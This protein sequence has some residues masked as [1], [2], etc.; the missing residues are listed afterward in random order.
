MEEENKIT[1][2]K[3]EKE[4]RGHVSMKLKINIWYFLKWGILLSVNDE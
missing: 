4:K 3:E 1:V 2:L